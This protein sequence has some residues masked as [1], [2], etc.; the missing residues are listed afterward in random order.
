MPLLEV[1]NLTKA[2]SHGKHEVRAVDG[3]SLNIFPGETLGLV[4]ESGSG[5]STFGRLLL[6]LVE[7]TSGSIRFEDRDLL[8]ASSR[9]M[10]RSRR[11]MQIIFLAGS[12]LPSR[13]HYC[14]AADYPRKFVYR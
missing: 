11:E 12:P 8:A 1:R 13:G 2:Y 6:R 7:P 4:G 5:K 10:R 14:G 3:V 9:E